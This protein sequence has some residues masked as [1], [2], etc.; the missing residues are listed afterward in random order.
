MASSHNI[1]VWIPNRSEELNETQF[2]EHF[3][4]ISKK[5]GVK[6]KLETLLNA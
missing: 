6:E 1:R 2:K 3:V 5:K 4:W